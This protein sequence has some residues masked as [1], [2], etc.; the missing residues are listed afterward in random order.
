MRP[1]TL[2]P[3]NNPFLKV[4]EPQED[5]NLEKDKE[6]EQPEDRLQDKDLKEEED[7]PKFVPLGSANVTARTSVNPV[8]APAQPTSSSSSSGFVFGQNL[9]ERV[10]IQENINNGDV[11]P[12]DHS[13]SNGTTELLFTNAAASVKD[14]QVCN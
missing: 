14:T 2:K 11:A 9:S 13:S 1:S 10:V 6:T 4:T 7:T 8:P 3:G 12:E 5:T